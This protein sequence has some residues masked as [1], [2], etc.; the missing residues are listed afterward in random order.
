[1]SEFIH[2]FLEIRGVIKNVY[3][4]ID[5]LGNFLEDRSR[6]LGK[7]YSETPSHWHSRSF[8]PDT[9]TWGYER[10]DYIT[11]VDDI[12]DTKHAVEEFLEFIEI[13]YT[14]LLDLIECTKRA[15]TRIGKMDDPD[16]D[17]IERLNPGVCLDGLDDVM[18][19]DHGLGSIAQRIHDVIQRG[20]GHRMLFHIR[21]KSELYHV[22]HANKFSTFQ[23]P[24]QLVSRE[25]WYT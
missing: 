6:S 15:D 10:N 11:E 3:I 21:N 2:R 14:D 12:C 18:E 16:E 5:E 8:Q 19:N 9:F 20:N 7:H 1:M 23:K 13:I 22:L 24:H 25:W 17:I 4:Q